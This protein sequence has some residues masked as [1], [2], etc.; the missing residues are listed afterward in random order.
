MKELCLEQKTLN[1]KS[2]RKELINK[3]FVTS[4]VRIDPNL[5]NISTSNNKN[6]IVGIISRFEFINPMEGIF[7]TS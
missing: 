3:T 1:W 5:T 6:K 4:N 2:N 7:G